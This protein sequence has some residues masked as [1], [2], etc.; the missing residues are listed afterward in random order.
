M[1][2]IG[3]QDDTTVPTSTDVLGLIESTDG[4]V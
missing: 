1:I 4:S 3:G 2:H